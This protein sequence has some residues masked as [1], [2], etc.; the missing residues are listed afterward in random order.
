MSRRLSGRYPK[1]AGR[2]RKPW[3]PMVRVAT[4]FTCPQKQDFQS[5][6][7]GVGPQPRHRDRGHCKADRLNFAYGWF[8]DMSSRGHSFG[9][10]DARSDVAEWFEQ[11]LGE[12]LPAE[13]DT[14]L[15]DRFGIVGDD[16]S[17]FMDAFAARFDVTCEDYR[18]YFHHEEEGWNFGALFFAPLNRRVERIPIT[19]NI[20]VRAIEAGQWPVQ[21]PP[22][23][24]P[25][26][27][28]DIRM[29]QALLLVPLALGM[30][31]FWERF[32]R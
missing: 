27:R 11:F 12:R 28:W 8:A 1:R 31:W 6:R 24:L 29:N 17:E 5:W 9:V 13:G 10:N 18:W 4:R 32:A 22:H 7:R 26:V 2:R 19:P 16:A 23:T 14:D 30:L 3:P 20:L 25:R 21:Y 15:F